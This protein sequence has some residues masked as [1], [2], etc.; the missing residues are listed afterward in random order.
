MSVMNSRWLRTK[1]EGYTLASKEKIVSAYLSRAKQIIPSIR[2]KERDAFLGTK[3]RASQAK[4]EEIDNKS[5]KEKTITF[6]RS[7]GSGKPEVLKPSKEL[8]RKM[9]DMDIL[10]Q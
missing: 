3:K 4:V 1:K 8:Y 2:D 10:T 7:G 5:S 6:G 9:S